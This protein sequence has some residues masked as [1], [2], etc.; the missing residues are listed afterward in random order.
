MAVETLTKEQCAAVAAVAERG[1]PPV[2]PCAGKPWGELLFI[3]DS[4][5][6]A[7]GFEQVYVL[8]RQ[9]SEALHK[10]EIVYTALI[11][12]LQAATAIGSEPWTIANKEM[13]AQKLTTESLLRPGDLK[14]SSLLTEVRRL[15]G[16]KTTY[17][18][19]KK[20]KS[21]WRK[22]K[23]DADDRVR[24][25][26]TEKGQL[27]HKKLMDQ[28]KALS[29]KIKA[30]FKWLDKQ[31]DF[32][33]EGFGAY[34]AAINGSLQWSLRNGIP[35][36]QVNFDVSCEAQLMRFYAGAS[37]GADWDPRSGK[38]GLQGQVDAKASLAEG[39]LQASG[40]FPDA[41][42]HL[43]RLSHRGDDGGTVAVEFG[44]VRAR[45]GLEVRAF[46]GA[47]VQGC[48]GIQAKLGRGLCGGDKPAKLGDKDAP[49]ASVSGKAFA[50]AEASG[51]L[52]GAIE[53]DNPEE[54][55]GG[56][57]DWRAFVSVS[58]GAG[59]AVGIGAEGEFKI[60]Y[61]GGRFRYRGSAG[62]VCG[63]GFSGELAGEIDARLIVEFIQFVY[64]KL[65]DSN[66]S[67]L[68]FISQE[69]FRALTM[70][71]VWAIGKAKEIGDYLGGKIAEVRRWW[72]NLWADEKAAEQLA[73]NII[74]AP[75]RLQF[76][77]PEAKGAIL[78]TLTQRFW[79]SWEESQE[80]AVLIVLSWVH[81][82]REFENVC[83]HMTPTGAKGSYEEGY[84]RL[85]KLLDG[86]D[87]DAFDIYVRGL[88]ARYRIEP[89]IDT[90]AVQSFS[91]TR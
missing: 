54:R 42:G 7:I 80:S 78:Y 66:F 63:W 47:S 86:S 21:H 38:I 82:R 51:S 56:V 13:V 90:A 75:S 88:R 68:A 12:S 15:V 22:Y 83:Q 87:Q 34:I 2:T 52:V 50:G 55:K 9:Q 53:W 20:I 14:G 30:E 72:V 23:L 19:S 27:D 1:A 48:I 79:T 44:R 70:L 41:R 62:V 39:R 6:P 57:P 35:P 69:A 58:V 59:V 91:P 29:P 43:L 77:T 45:L 89:L 11:N 60:S 73:E 28:F 65:K 76:L 67:V 36:G 81:T 40:Y 3:L 64:H 32:G 10:E 18:P 33:I 17:V 16:R 4:I 49:K 84:E 24:S 26:R 5:D 37:L 31:I 61:E 85:E 25:M 74:A 46:V 8:T 71:Q